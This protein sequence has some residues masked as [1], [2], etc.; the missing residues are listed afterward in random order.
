MTEGG[1]KYGGGRKSVFVCVEKRVKERAQA[2]PEDHSSM[3]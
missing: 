2:V 1:R 3:I